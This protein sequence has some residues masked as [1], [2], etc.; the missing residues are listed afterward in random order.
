[1]FRWF[2]NLKDIFLKN[3]KFLF[4]NLKST[5]KNRDFSK[6]SPNFFNKMST[7]VGV[8]VL[9]LFFIFFFKIYVPLNPV[10]NET[11]IF[12]VERGWGDQR[13]A[14]E[15]EKLGVIRSNYFFRFYAVMSFQHSKLQA[16]RY[17]LS[18]RM[19]TYQIVKKMVRGDVIRNRIIIL[20]GWTVSQIGDYLESKEVCQKD[21][22]LSIAEKDYS[23][24]FDFLKDKPKDISLEGFLFPDTYE[25]SDRE[26][27]DN[28]L[29]MMLS[30]FDRKLSQELREEIESQNKTIFDIITMAAMIEKEVR[31]MEEKKIVSGILWKRLSVDMPLQIDATVNYV[32]GKSDPAVLIRDTKIDSPYNTY[33]HKGLP[34]GPI[35][36][37]GLNSILAAIYPTETKYWFYLSDGRTIFSET[38]DQHVAAKQKYL[39]GR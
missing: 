32:T 35:S 29:I 34:K 30:N 8:L 6:M 24:R 22:F 17:N 37:P 25:V 27:C 16:G 39:K 15:L 4:L 31:I 19:S 5:I 3:F 9:C 26:T 38:F 2:K 33:K 10:S 14:K 1:L 23:D 36:N 28:L 7:F 12:T 18:P 13:V 20:E 21:Y 11:V